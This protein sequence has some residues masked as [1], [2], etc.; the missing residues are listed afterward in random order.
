MN[1][2]KRKIVCVQGLG[3]VGMATAVAVSCSRDTHNSPLYDVIGVELANDR[4]QKITG[5]IN[6]GIFP[7]SSRSLASR[8]G[9]KRRGGSLLT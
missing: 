1:S 2:G 5:Q 8:E 3:F 9:S 7:I 6:S 4:G